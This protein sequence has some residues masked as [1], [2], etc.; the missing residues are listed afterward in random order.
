M[1]NVRTHR[2]I[3]LATTKPRRNYLVAE[4]NYHATFF[5]LKFIGH[6]KQNTDT[7]E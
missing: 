3:K 4:Q 7:Y 5:F 1:E 2:V 6:K